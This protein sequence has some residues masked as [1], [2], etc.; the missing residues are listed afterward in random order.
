MKSPNFNK[1]R[2]D[3]S[4]ALSK[5]SDLDEIVDHILLDIAPLPNP[6]TV[7]AQ[8]LIN[9]LKPWFYAAIAQVMD[10]VIDFDAPAIHRHNAEVLSMLSFQFDPRKRP[11]LLESFI[12]YK[13]H[14]Q[15]NDYL[16]SSP[17]SPQ[18]QTLQKIIDVSKLLGSLDWDNAEIAIGGGLD[19]MIEQAM[20]CFKSYFE[21]ALQ[22]EDTRDPDEI[23]NTMMRSS[24]DLTN[25]TLL[26]PVQ[27]AA[28]T[29]YIQ[30]GNIPKS[31]Y[32]S[33]RDQYR[34]EQELDQIELTD[35]AKERIIKSLKTFNH[36]GLIPIVEKAVI[37]AD[38]EHSTDTLGCPIGFR[39]FQVQK[40]WDQVVDQADA[41]GLL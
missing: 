9:Y 8:A 17:N 27:L 35:E 7:E 30:A 39:P 19:T 12:E 29:I 16:A 37:I 33:G 23:K 41:I 25:A 22:Q 11:D 26:N 32:D 2:R 21:I 1:A 18:L 38:L 14:K 4:I 10:Q 28:L 40:I 15:L 3:E 13:F 24:L 36:T 20:L 34:F 6:E 5:E 31:I